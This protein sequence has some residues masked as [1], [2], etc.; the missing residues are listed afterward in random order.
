MPKNTVSTSPRTSLTA[1]EGGAMY[2]GSHERCGP[3]SRK[4]CKSRRRRVVRRRS[5]GCADGS[6]TTE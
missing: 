5:P 4:T 1:S 2:A 6:S 3:M